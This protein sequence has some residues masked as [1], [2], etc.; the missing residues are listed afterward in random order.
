MSHVDHKEWSCRPVDF[1][2]VPCHPGDFK[3][4]SCRPVDFKK[5]PCRLSL[6]PK[7]G[8]VAVS[9]LRVHAPK[10]DYLSFYTT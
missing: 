1:K 6:R 5:V 7:N 2:K 8:R 9:I 10:S 3:K 4:L